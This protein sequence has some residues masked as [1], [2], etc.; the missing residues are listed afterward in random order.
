LGR[1]EFEG[2]FDENAARSRVM[3]RLAR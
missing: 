1:L 3:V 2:K